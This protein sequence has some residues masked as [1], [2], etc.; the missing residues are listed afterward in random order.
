MAP[1]PFHPTRALNAQARRRCYSQKENPRPCRT[2]DTTTVWP[3]CH[4]TTISALCRH[5]AALCGQT[6]AIPQHYT[7]CSRH[8]PTASALGRRPSTQSERH[9]GTDYAGYV[10]STISGTVQPSPTLCGHHRRCAATPTLWHPELTRHHHASA[11]ATRVLRPPLQRDPRTSMGAPSIVVRT[12][13]GTDADQDTPRSHPPT[14]TRIAMP[15]AEA[16]IRHQSST[17]AKICK[18]NRHTRHIVRQYATTVHNIM[19]HNCTCL[20]LACKRRRHMP[21]CRARQKHTLIYPA[22]HA[23]RY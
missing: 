9:R 3:T 18:D 19:Q 2:A 22:L 8:P 6:D 15:P 5:H 14:S 11:Y 21:D 23:S 4:C 17:R 10:F 7:T 12:M 13:T 1:H 16:G 20:S